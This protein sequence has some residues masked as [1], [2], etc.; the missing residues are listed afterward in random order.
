MFY[1][2][3]LIITFLPRNSI[4]YV[5]YLWPTNRIVWLVKLVKRKIDTLIEQFICK[6]LM[7]LSDALLYLIIE[8]LDNSRSYG[9]GISGTTTHVLIGFTIFIRIVA[10]AA[11]SS[12]NR[13]CRI[14]I[15]IA[16]T[17]LRSRTH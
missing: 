7:K 13:Q 15:R 14:R 16:D 2:Y 9:L 11:A 3:E 1:K 10:I 8:R 4:Y 12:K 5:N 6:R 17:F